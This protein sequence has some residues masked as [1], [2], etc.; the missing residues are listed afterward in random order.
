MEGGLPGAGNR[1]EDLLAAVPISI[2]ELRRAVG[3]FET[4]TAGMVEASIRTA[5]R[6]LAEL[7]ACAALIDNAGEQGQRS[8]DLIR[9]LAA[10]EAVGQVAAELDMLDAVAGRVWESAPLRRLLNSVLGRD[11]GGAPDGEGDGV[12]PGVRTLV[13]AELPALPSAYDDGD[14][15]DDLMALA[16]RGVEL[17]PRLE[18]AHAERISRVAAHLV[19][20]VEGAAKSGF[21]QEGFARASLSEARRAWALWERCLGERRRDLGR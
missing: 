4:D 11:A 14:A 7:D 3:R 8:A 17:A 6:A 16:A 21:A 12:A 19:S 5:E 18:L 10:K 15:F 2:G 13:E 1:I 20:V 9:E